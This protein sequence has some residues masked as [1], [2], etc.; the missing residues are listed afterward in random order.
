MIRSIVSVRLV[1]FAAL[2]SFFCLTFTV[3]AGDVK[4]ETEIERLLR[5]LE[6]P[7]ELTFCAE[8]VALDDEESREAFEREMLISIANSHQVILWLK[9]A[10]RFFP[11]IESALKQRNLPDDLKYIAVIESALLLHV[12]SPKGAR[13]PWQFMPETAR[14]YNLKITSDIDERRNIY[15]ATR[16]ALNYFEELHKRFHSWTLAAA[17]YNMGEEGLE[18]EILLQKTDD[19]F[20]LYLP[21]ETQRY[22]FRILCAKLIMSDPSRYGFVLPVTALY[23]PLDGIEISFSC[24][25]RFPLSLLTQ[26]ADITFKKFKEYNPDILG[27]FLEKGTYEFYMPRKYDSRFKEILP[28]LLKEW[29]AQKSKAT[30]TVQRGDSL[31]SIARKFGVPL[32]ALLKVNSLNPKKHIYPG[33]KIVIPVQKTR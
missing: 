18:S 21:L 10:N 9:R 17:A 27:H 4:T 25:E 33:E 26:A 30:Y 13:G 12:R 1:L 2:V 28:E 11:T 16:A 29:K 7:A 19:Y 22:V 31:Y 3:F 15:K 23:K 20:N 32:P 8:K 6:I 5:S 24:Q 14:N